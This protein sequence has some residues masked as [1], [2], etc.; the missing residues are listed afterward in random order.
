MTVEEHPETVS[1]PVETPILPKINKGGRPPGSKNRVT[2]ERRDWLR[3]IFEKPKS[4]QHLV[5][6]IEE[7]QYKTEPK[8]AALVIH[9]HSMAFGKPIPQAAQEEHRSPLL[10]VTQHP[11]GTYDPLA[12]KAKALQERKAAA[13]LPPAGEVYAPP[14][15]D[16]PDALVVVE[17][18]DARTLSR[19]TPPKSA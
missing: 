14:S 6:L 2:K 4:R 12:D 5:D 19:T 16:D 9:L 15:P 11:I 8:L 18:G 7:G 13:A 10:F 3:A 1:G 17:T